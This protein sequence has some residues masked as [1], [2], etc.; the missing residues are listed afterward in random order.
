MV[1]HRSIIRLSVVTLVAGVVVAIGAPAHATPTSIGHLQNDNSGKCLLIQGN[2]Q[3]AP[4]VQYTC[5]AY[6]DQFW[7]FLYD[8]GQNSDQIQN[9]NSNQCLTARPDKTVVQQNC[10]YASNLYQSWDYIPY[11]TESHPNAW[12]IRNNG[13]GMANGVGYCLVVQGGANNTRVAVWDCHPEY[14]DQLW[15][16][17]ED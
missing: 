11:F 17:L 1:L 3:N 6:Q 7:A 12:L 9:Y 5:M 13:M 4:A 15:D 10:V 2:A 14:M 8:N 16:F